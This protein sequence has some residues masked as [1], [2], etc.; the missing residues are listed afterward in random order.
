LSEIKRAVM[1]ILMVLESD[2]PPDL[3]VENEIKS[4]LSAKHTVILACLSQ[5]DHDIITSWN[6]CKIYKKGISKF[7]YKSS[8]GALKFPFYFN[9]WREHLENIMLNEHP[10]AIHIHDLPLARIGAEIKAKYGL[11]YVLD[12]HENWPAL[13]SISA[14]TKTLIGRLLSSKRQWEKYEINSCWRADKIIVV[15]EEAKERLKGIGISS[16]KI[17]IVA[18]YS[19]LSDYDNLPEINKKED[20]FT[21]FYAGGIS[22]HRGLQYIIRA[23][24]E[25]IEFY[26]NLKLQI[27]GDGNYRMRLEKLA[28]KLEVIKYIDFAGKVPYKRVLEELSQANIALIPHIKS[29]HTDNTIPHK[30]FQYMYC[31][32]PVLASNCRPLER[33]IKESNAG[34]IYQWDSPSEFAKVFRIAY[35]DKSYNEAEVKKCVTEKYNWV[36]ESKKLIRLYS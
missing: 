23:L 35:Y 9:F 33:I 5:S 29:E 16:E 10:D 7:T 31:G 2:F 36:S 12:L 8:V 6:G 17:E 11:I 30:L 28:Y 19:N 3:R 26:P 14:H 34:F 22:E 27:L 24:P 32:K 20:T 4:L 18:N 21:L 1:K 25:I 15:I 13:L